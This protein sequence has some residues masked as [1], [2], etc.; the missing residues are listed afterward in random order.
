MDDIYN[1]SFANLNL[2]S[3]L[4]SKHN[5]KTGHWRGLNYL[6]GMRNIRIAMRSSLSLLAIFLLS[7]LLAGC[8]NEGISAT[9]ERDE[10]HYR[11]ATRLL[12]ED[13]RQEALA[14]FLRVIEKRR[15]APESH[16]EAGRLY[17]DHI[18]DP[19]T[20]I[21]H[22][23]KY[24]ESRSDSEESDLVRQLIDTSKKAF[25]R[26]LPAQPYAN[27]IE[28]LDLLA[29]VGQQ[30]A[31]NLRLKQRLAASNQK[32]SE[33]E[34]RRVLFQTLPPAS[35]PSRAELT[36]GQTTASQESSGRRQE[37]GERPEFY[38]VEG[39]DT[40]SRISYKIYGNPG[41]WMSIFQANR[42]TLED[43]NDLRIGMELR[44][45]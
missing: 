35:I 24:L 2:A 4:A 28:R 42:D 26:G 23:R 43:P 7:L 1:I 36:S 25:A 27:G 3:C 38:I 31:E 30:K 22:F 8:S 18:K 9:Q 16:L 44:I 33:W 20:A 14:A 41:N 45:P 6:Q 10:T 40:L 15:D 21:Y 13:R 17:L 11:R 19:I 37:A 32:I 12:K 34:R 5:C 39:G 29:L